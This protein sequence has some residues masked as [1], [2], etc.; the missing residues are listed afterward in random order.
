MNKRLESVAIALRSKDISADGRELIIKDAVEY[1]QD[2]A[3]VLAISDSLLF[4]PENIAAA[5][6]EA[7]YDPAEYLAQR[8]G[9]W[10]F[11]RGDEDCMG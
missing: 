8:S 3:V 7:G 10:S 6:V 5:I 1:R 2:A 9:Y 4:A 11:A